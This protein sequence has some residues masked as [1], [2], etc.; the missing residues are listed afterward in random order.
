MFEQHLTL[1]KP[2]AHRCFRHFGLDVALFFANVHK[3]IKTPTSLVEAPYQPYNTQLSALFPI[4]TRL[5]SVS[6]QPS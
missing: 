2:F 1:E 5:V 6:N 3:K 4:E